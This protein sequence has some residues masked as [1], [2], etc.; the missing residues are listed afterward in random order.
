MN[1]RQKSVDIIH[2]II[3]DQDI[4]KN[5]EAA[6]HDKFHTDIK[7]YSQKVRSIIFNLRSK[8]KF[9]EDILQKK[10]LVQDIPDMIPAEIDSSL[11]DPIF[12]K[13]AKKQKINEIINKLA[14]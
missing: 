2:S 10:I 4:A 14:A 13:A 3:L 12:H 8:S 1:K 6:I 5:I 7:K 9:R 11:W